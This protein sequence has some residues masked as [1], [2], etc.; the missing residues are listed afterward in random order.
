[1]YISSDAGQPRDCAEG[2]GCAQQESQDVC[3]I[4]IEEQTTV[5]TLKSF[6]NIRQDRQ[7]ENS[8]RAKMFARF[9]SRSRPQ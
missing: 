1:V 8:K 5:I 9:K 3:K 2:G 6:T 4:Q 7:I